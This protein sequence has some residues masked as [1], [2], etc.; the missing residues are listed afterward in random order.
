MNYK[1]ITF[2]PFAEHF[3][4]LIAELGLSRY[5]RNNKLGKKMINCDEFIV[6]LR[7]SFE[8]AKLAKF[9]TSIL[10]KIFAKI[11]KNND[12][13]ISF[14]EYLDWVKRFLAVLKYYGDEFWVPEDDADDNDD[15]FDKDVA[16]PP[17]P[18]DRNK[19]QFVFSDYS[20]A[21]K[22]RQRVLECLIPYDVDKNHEFDQKEIENAMVGLLKE[23]ENELSY[24]TKNVFRYDV[25]NDG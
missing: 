23:N 15:G 3:I 20:F 6:I 24:V 7:N 18:I 8:F 1:V 5:A 12:G 4:F 19:V 10:C 13:L 25:N 11:D 21:R 16:P 22:V 14:D 2:E 9:R 17:A